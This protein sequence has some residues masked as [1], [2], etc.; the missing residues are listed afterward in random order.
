MEEKEQK[1]KYLI[2]RQKRCRRQK[3]EWK[4]KKFLLQ[5]S[6]S[7]LGQDLY[8]HL[9]QNRIAWFCFSICNIYNCQIYCFNGVGLSLGPS[10]L[11]A[12]VSLYI[13]AGSSQN[14]DGI[15]LKGMHLPCNLYW[16]LYLLSLELRLMKL[17][18]R[19]T[20]HTMWKVTKTI[21][22]TS[23]PPVIGIDYHYQ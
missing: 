12:S 10:Q 1:W 13:Y 14:C 3:E 5:N 2:Q 17:K 21:I 6:Y 9:D 8:S 20:E 7:E 4:R 22:W 16:R 18:L 19:L 23:F 11:I 15:N